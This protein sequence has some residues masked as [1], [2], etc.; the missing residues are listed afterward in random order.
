MPR[1]ARQCRHAEY[2]HTSNTFPV[3]L[4]WVSQPGK[5]D[6]AAQPPDHYEVKRRRV[7]RCRIS[8]F[9]FNFRCTLT[10]WSHRSL[11]GNTPAKPAPPPDANIK[12]RQSRRCE[13]NMT[14]VSGRFPSRSFCHAPGV[15]RAAKR[16][17]T[18]HRPR[19][20]WLPRLATASE[21]FSGAT[22][23]TSF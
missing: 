20:S 21:R 23:D 2:P 14:T 4:T 13:W 12:L 17:V 9:F 15:A 18:A 19:F 22:Y 7:P 8:R 5:D 1:K 6:L 11:A 16:T 10:F 3:C